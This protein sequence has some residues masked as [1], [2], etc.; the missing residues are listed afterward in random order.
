MKAKVFRSIRARLLVALLL[1]AVLTIAVGGLFTYVLVREHLLAEFDKFLADKVHYHKISAVQDGNRLRFQISQPVW[2]QIHNAKNPEYF[3]FRFVDGRDLYRSYDGDGAPALPQ[4]GL[5]DDALVAQDCV[6]PNGNRGRCMGLVFIPERTEGS[7]G[8]ARLH[9]VVARDREQMDE[10]LQRLR[11]LIWGAMAMAATLFGAATVMIIARALRPVGELSEQ[12]AAMPVGVGGGRFE[13]ED[14]PKEISPVV[15]RLNELMARVDGAIENERQF[16]SNAAH[17]LR[18]PL[19][20][21]RSQL[22]LA[23][24]SER[25]EEKDTVAFGHAFKIQLQMEGVVENLLALARL[26]AGRE[27]LAFTPVEVPAVLKRRWKPF[28][29]TAAERGLKVSW[30]IGEVPETFVTSAS[31]FGIL[32]SNLYD[33]AASYAPEGGQVEISAALEG[34]DLLLGVRNTNPGVDPERGQALLERFRRGDPSAAGGRGRAG[35]GLSLCERIAA[36][37]DGEMSLDI[38]AGWFAVR[39]SLPESS[40]AANSGTEEKT[41]PV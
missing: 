14:A 41:S 3:Q 30:Q 2:K 27:Q 8:A 15:G 34:G 31:L 35:I 1:C 11:W 12:I 23:L 10:A 40:V 19:A 13:L 9:L 24:A 17:E 7:E 38:D 20:G 4:V 21:L 18:N 25:D 32:I 26:D 16:T 36:T 37:L 22:E 28:F 6:L 39:I 29:E 5:N 33:N